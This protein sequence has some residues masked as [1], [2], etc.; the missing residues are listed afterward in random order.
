M[1][2]IPLPGQEALARPAEAKK[3]GAMAIFEEKYGDVVRV[4]TMTKDSVELCGGTHVGRTGRPVVLMHHYG[5]DSFST[6]D[7]WWT[8][9]QRL[10]YWNAIA[11]YNVVAIFTGHQHLTVSDR[12]SGSTSSLVGSPR[13][14]RWERPVGAGG[15]PTGIP[16]YIAG[17]ALYG[18]Y[19][20][21]EF[22]ASNQIRVTLRDETGAAK[23][24][25]NSTH[26]TPLW[27]N[28]NNGQ[29][30]LGA[31]GAGLR[32]LQDLVVAAD[33]EGLGIAQGLLERGGEFVY[34]H[35]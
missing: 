12:G 20:D 6:G 24:F 9:E 29:S 32:R 14:I 33:R 26:N 23:E 34:T 3:R 19:L 27:M 31:F 22:N 16:T 21:V 8:P 15:G 7:G 11:S 4:L 13:F 35:G 2:S 30:G 10:A 28:A 17:A 18:A 5:F 25:K 1:G